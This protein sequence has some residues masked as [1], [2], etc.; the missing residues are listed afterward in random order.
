[1]S[2]NNLKRSGGNEVRLLDLHSAAA[3]LSLSYWTLRTML[4]NGEISYVRAGRRILVDKH[5]LETWIE[6]NKYKE[7]F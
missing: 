1:M 5:D 2:Q 6:R 3:F 7:A 4:H